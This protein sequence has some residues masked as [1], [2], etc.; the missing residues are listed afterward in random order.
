[1]EELRREAE[2][3]QNIFSELQEDNECLERDVEKY[4][5]TVKSLSGQ[6]EDLVFELEKIT[7]KEEEA[8]FILNRKSR[9]EA[10][11]SKAEAQVTKNHS[12]RKY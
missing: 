10:L 4:K 6:N 5:D 1:V 12:T 3:L 2:K 9:I 7:E 8:R 11:I